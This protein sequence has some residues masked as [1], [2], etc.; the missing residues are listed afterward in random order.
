MI[1]RLPWMC[2]GHEDYNP[3][4]VGAITQGEVAAAILA[5]G[6]NVLFSI[7]RVKRYDLVI[8][9]DRGRFFRVQCKT[10]QL[11]NGAVIFRPFSQRAAKEETGWR[12]EAATYEGDIEFFGVY[13]PDNDKVYLIPI[14]DVPNCS[15][16][17]LRVDPPK[18]N[19]RS[20]IRWAKD[21]EVV[22]MPPPRR[23]VFGN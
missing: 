15:A 16:C 4:D 22:P 3:N 2:R 21:Y 5:K 12:R 6:W 19:Q 1:G 18:N 11:V 17:S 7:Y 8:E 13:C 9:D 14:Q 23:Q 10:G 20:R